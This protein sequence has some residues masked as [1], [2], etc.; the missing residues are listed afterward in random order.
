MAWLQEVGR[1]LSEILNIQ[2]FAIHGV[3]VTIG[4]VAAFLLSVV[5]AV[6]VGRIASRAIVRLLRN[7]SGVSDQG[8]IYALGRIAQYAVTVVGI[9]IGLENVGFSITT[10]AAIGAVF[11]VGIGFGL[12]N[13]HL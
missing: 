9:L 7:A 6:L 10:L 5:V 4:S 2:L 13:V 11:A 3:H 1:D 8:T 12:Q